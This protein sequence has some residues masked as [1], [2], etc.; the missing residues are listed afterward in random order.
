MAGHVRAYIDGFNLYHAIADLNRPVLKW[1]NQ[2]KLC[3]S[4][5]ET[6]ETLDQANFFTAV[7]FFDRDKQQRH[8]NYLA[9]LRATGVEVH[10][11]NFKRSSKFCH[12]YQRYCRFREEKQT[13]VSIAIRLVRDALEKKIDTAMLITADTDQIPTVELVQGLGV[14][15]R[16]ILPPGRASEAKD[17]AK[18]AA[19]CRELSWEHLSAYP[20]P[21]SVKSGGRTVATMPA[22]YL[23]GD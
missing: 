1:L 5:L 23:A 11:G 8:V 10:E 17:L 4:L 22:S 14:P 3:Q 12:D 21:R 13:D 18:R 19:E 20:L 2:A 7:W 9:A 15:V 6:G 16:I